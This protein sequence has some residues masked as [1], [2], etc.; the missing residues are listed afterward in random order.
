M[1]NKIQ[2]HVKVTI[3]PFIILYFTFACVILLLYVFPHQNVGSMNLFLYS[4]ESLDTQRTFVKCWL[5]IFSQPTSWGITNIMCCPLTF[6]NVKKVPSF[7]LRLRLWGWVNKW[8]INKIQKKNQTQIEGVGDNDIK[9]MNGSEIIGYGMS[10]L[11]LSLIVLYCSILFIFPKILTNI[12]SDE[13]YNNV[14]GEVGGRQNGCCL[15]L[16][17]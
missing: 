2:I 15:V 1:I 8:K 16:F 5:S 6:Y 13:H 12:A 17:S 11:P 10:S 14:P 4:I 9:L 7:G 3:R